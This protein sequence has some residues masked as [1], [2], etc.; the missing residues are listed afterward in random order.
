M[1]HFGFGCAELHPQNSSLYNGETF[2]TKERIAPQKQERKF[3][4][5]KIIHPSFAP[6]WSS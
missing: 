3:P 6:L 1:R 2:P 4:R 5:Q